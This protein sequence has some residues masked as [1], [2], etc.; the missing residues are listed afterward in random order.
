M[1]EAKMSDSVPTTFHTRKR[2]SGGSTVLR[3]FAWVSVLSL[4]ICWTV[5]FLSYFGVS[6]PAFGAWFGGS[7]LVT[8]VAGISSFSPLGGIS[9]ALVLLTLLAMLTYGA[10]GAGC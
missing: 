2:F 7:L 8:F 6:Q 5:C 10:A 9:A 4:V 3:V 1:N